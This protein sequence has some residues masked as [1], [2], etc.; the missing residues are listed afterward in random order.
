MNPEKEVKQISKELKVVE[1]PKKRKRR[2]S[3]TSPNKIRIY[4]QQLMIKVENDEMTESKARL[5]TQQAEVILRAINAK[6]DAQR[7][8]ELEN[9]L[10]ELEY[11]QKGGF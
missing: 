9:K 5:L 6:E 8:H 7:M 3:L 4:I 1:M 11:Q 10:I 2:L